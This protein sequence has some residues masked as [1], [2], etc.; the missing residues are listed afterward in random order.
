M[1]SLLMA[2][3]NKQTHQAEKD[4]L[5]GLNNKNAFLIFRDSLVNKSK[6][7]LLTLFVLDADHFKSINDK[8]GHLK[9]DQALK[10]IAAILETS[11]KS[12]TDKR[13]ALYRYAGDEFV[14][15]GNGIEDGDISTLQAAIKET[16]DTVNETNRTKGEQYVISLSCGYS[17]KLC[18]NEVEFDQLLKEADESM[19]IEKAER[20]RKA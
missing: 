9:G 19:Y 11:I 17:T 6:A 20:H 16:S 5:T 13:L 15:I 14:I 18:K 4:G 2:F 7:S 1:F 12:I 8:Y 10:D 3:V